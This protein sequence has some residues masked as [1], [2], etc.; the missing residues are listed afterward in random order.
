MMEL[1]NLWNIFVNQA[2]SIKK[3]KKI[4]NQI[5]ETLSMFGYKF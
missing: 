3:H 1:L 2:K 5:T 4:L